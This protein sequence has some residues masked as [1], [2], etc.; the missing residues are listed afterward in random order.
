MQVA[1]RQDI[2]RSEESRY[3]YR[4][5]GVLLVAIGRSCNAVSQVVR[6]DATTAGRWVRRFEHRGFAGLRVWRAPGTAK[7]LNAPG[8]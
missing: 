1:I 2:D 8:A 6:G 5:H 4:S 7:S 3:D